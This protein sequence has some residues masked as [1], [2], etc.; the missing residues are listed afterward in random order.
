MGKIGRHRLPGQAS[1]RAFQRRARLDRHRQQGGHRRPGPRVLSPRL[2]ALPA[3]RG[4]EVAE[5]RGVRQQGPGHAGHRRRAAHDVDLRA[6]RRRAGL[7]GFRRRVRDSRP[8]RRMARSRERASTKKDGRIVSHH[9]ARAARR[10]AGKMFID[11]T[12]EGDLMAAAGVDYHVGREANSELRRKVERRADRR[13]APPASLRRGRE[14]D[15]SLRRARRSDQRRAAAHQRPIRRANTAR[16]TT[17]S[18]PTA[19]ACA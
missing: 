11:A 16:A 6:A 4:L 18:R 2:A 5:A 14:A 17:G 9:H 15:Q 1:R 19:S 12:Y 3:A 10:I 13:A 8:S 7:R